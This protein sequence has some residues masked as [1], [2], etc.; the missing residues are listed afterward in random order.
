MYLKVASERSS[1]RLSFFEQEI[2]CLL[3]AVVRTR[4]GFAFQP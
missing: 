2:L 1:Y 4:F 3:H